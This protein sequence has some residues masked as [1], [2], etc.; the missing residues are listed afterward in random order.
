MNVTT[1]VTTRVSRREREV[2]GRAHRTTR[3]P[4]RRGTQRMDIDARKP[5][6]ADDMANCD[7]LDGGDEAGA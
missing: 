1:T 5:H 6:D 2:T 7:Q 4:T 3:A